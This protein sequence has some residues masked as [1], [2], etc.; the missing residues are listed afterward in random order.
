LP[1]EGGEVYWGVHRQ[2]FEDPDFAGITIPEL[3]KWAVENN[4]VMHPKD[5]EKLE[6]RLDGNRDKVQDAILPSINNVTSTAM[7]LIRVYQPGMKPKDSQAI[8]GQVM[9]FV[10]DEVN[11]ETAGGTKELTPAAMRR[12]AELAAS[13]GGTKDKPFAADPE[14]MAEYR[15]D[16]A[17]W[18]GLLNRLSTVKL[19]NGKPVAGETD[20]ATRK[21]M[22]GI[23]RRVEGG[24]PAYRVKDIPKF[25]TEALAEDFVPLSATE[26]EQAYT[27]WL[28]PGATG[29]PVERRKAR[30]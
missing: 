21:E 10:A 15:E 4:V 17:R 9:K 7:K 13:R 8:E 20:R 30:R 6:A 19:E 16:P 24:K 23:I 18:G 26:Q 11:V 3:R 22:L 1:M 2:L 28:L 29:L 14:A 5:W 27:N 25:F 12:I